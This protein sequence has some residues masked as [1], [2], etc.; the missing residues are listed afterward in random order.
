MIMLTLRVTSGFPA[1]AVT[2]NRIAVMVTMDVVATGAIIS[3]R[4][5][6]FVAGLA[7]RRPR[8]TNL[9]QINVRQGSFNNMT[10]WKGNAG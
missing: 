2:D 5:H 10:G 4:G 9:G 3:L 7:C 8:P 1:A 6:N